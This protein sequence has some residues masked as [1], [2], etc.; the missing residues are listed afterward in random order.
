MSTTLF[1]LPDEI[2]NLFNFGDFRDLIRFARITSSFYSRLQASHYI[3][4]AQCVEYNRYRMWKWKK[5]LSAVSISS[6]THWIE[7]IKNVE[8]IHLSYIH[9]DDD[10]IAMLK[11]AKKVYIRGLRNGNIE[12][13]RNVQHLDLSYSLVSID[14]SKL[15]HGTIRSLTIEHSR[16]TGIPSLGKIYTL[17]DVSLEGSTVLYPPYNISS[18]AN[19]LFLRKANFSGIGITDASALCHVHELNLRWTG[20]KDVSALGRVHTL[21]LDGTEVTNVSALGNVY[22]L[23]LVGCH[24]VR[25]VSALGRVYSLTLDETGVIDVS[26]LGNVSILSLR[27]TRVSD[28]SMLGGVKEELDI[29]NTDVTDISALRK[30]KNLIVDNLGIKFDRSFTNIMHTKTQMLDD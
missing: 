11:G 10:E 30:I 9:I 27:R 4:I 20:V 21:N 2:L 6:V 17:E 16:I 13:L 24:N 8:E 15:E 19:L 12:P 22:D 26:A 25:D 28:A 7:D 18:L 29:S 23:S 3:K 14:I 1:D 5:H